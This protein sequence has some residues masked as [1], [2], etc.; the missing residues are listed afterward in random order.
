MCDGDSP[1]FNLQVKFS[2]IASGH[3]FYFKE[4]QVYLIVVKRV[5]PVVS[6]VCI[7]A[8]KSAY[9]DSVPRSTGGT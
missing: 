7:S 3:A 1:S 8:L 6:Y 5:L 4:S 9:I 2:Q